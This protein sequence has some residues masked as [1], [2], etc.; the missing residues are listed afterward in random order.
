MEF[1]NNGAFRTELTPKERLLLQEIRRRK[2]ELA[3]EIQQLKD[4]ISEIKKELDYMDQMDENTQTENESKLRNIGRKKFNIDPA[5]G[6]EYLYK[7][8]L[9]NM[10]VEDVAQFL[11]KEEGLNKVKKGEYLGEKD[12]F[13][14]SVLKNYVWLH[15]FKDK[16]LV[17]ALRD[18]LW[19]FRL[20]GEAQKI[21]RM[22][23]AF[24]EHYCRQNNTAFKMPDTCYVLSFSIIMLNTNL[25]NPSVKDKQSL[26]GFINMNR[27]INDGGDLAPEML[28]ELYESIRDEPFKIPEDDGNDLTKTFFNAEREGMLTKEGGLHKTWKP[29][30]FILKDNCLYYFKNKGDK[31]PR[32]IIPLENLRVKECNEIKRKFCFEIYAPNSGSVI[33]ACKTDSDGKVVVGHHDS[34][35]ICA[36]SADE[37]ENWIID[38]TN[39]ITRDPFYEMLQAR[40]KRATHLLQGS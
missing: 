35:R 9:I 5:K 25:H 6:L 32:G 40:K 12:D 2:Q 33:K 37:R 15:D 19:K 34:Y 39:S 7:N 3:V 23:E 14:I 1:T 27:G 22:M 30:Y 8:C 20:P 26:D 17:A 13:N 16:H 24:A 36:S 38:I 18:Y 10:T 4:E 21:D 11:Y 28:K 29:R 31:E